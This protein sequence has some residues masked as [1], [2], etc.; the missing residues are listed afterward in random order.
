M[1]SQAILKHIDGGSNSE[2]K[3]IAIFSLRAFIYM[4]S[5]TQLLWTHLSKTAKAISQKQTIKLLN[6]VPIPAY[7]RSWQDSAGFLLMLMLL[8]MLIFEPIIWCVAND[9]WDANDGS[10]FSERCPSGLDVAWT[11]SVFSA[12]AMF[13]YHIL[14]IDLAVLSTKVSAYVLVCFRMLSEFFL[15]L[16][17]LVGSLLTFATALS[18]IK[19]K[20][21][22]FEGIHYGLLHL[23]EM[24]L[25]EYNG[26]KYK[27]FESDPLVL[28]VVFVFLFVVFAFLFNMLVAQLTCAYEVIYLDMMGY[29]RLERIEII[30]AT[31]PLVSKKRW[32]SFVQSLKLEQ[33]CEFGAGDIGVNG[34][35]QI[36]E[37]A[38][39]NP[40]TEDSIRRHG[41]STAVENQWPT[42]EVLGQG[43]EEE[44]FE[45]LETLI[46]KTVKRMTKGSTT[47]TSG[48]S[49][50]HSSS[51]SSG[52]SGDDANGD[53]GSK[54]SSQGD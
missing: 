27:K 10:L 3:R 36:M 40:T 34:G 30:V 16:L 51:Q 38:N 22:D 18:V 23:L 32:N 7:L 8:T 26:E 39:L 14:L 9:G 49:L 37:A 17:A 33:K 29:A 31:I 44:R 6:I 50:G 46:N 1:I 47:K 2:V 35:I 41:G 19:H 24:A 4:F 15:F 11:Y 42:E 13:L 54:G 21:K 12:L 25:G 20:Q 45:R 53:S 28:I 48:G 5:M 43:D 52:K